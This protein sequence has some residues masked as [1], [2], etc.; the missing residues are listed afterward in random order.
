MIA[1]DLA[2]GRY[3][4]LDCRAERC[5]CRDGFARIERHGM[6]GMFESPGEA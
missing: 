3:Y 6:F 1:T 4:N 2:R 5:I